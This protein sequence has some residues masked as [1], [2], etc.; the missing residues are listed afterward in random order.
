MRLLR[1]ISIIATFAVLAAC[2]APPPPTYPAA[3]FQLAA[4]DPAARETHQIL[5]RGANAVGVEI[6][7]D[8]LEQQRAAGKSENVF[9]SPASIFTAFGLLYAG[10]DG[11]TAE[12][13]S[14][15]MHFS[16]P[17]A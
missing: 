13:I 3:D 12:E 6:Y 9:I 1:T 11:S 17:D 15:V 7:L 14:R 16:H 10:A 2:Q 8:L 5:A 4:A